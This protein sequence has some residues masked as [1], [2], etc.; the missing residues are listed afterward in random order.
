MAAIR[1]WEGF[2]G[3]IWD[4]EWWRSVRTRREPLIDGDS[5]SE[6]PLVRSKRMWSECAVCQRRVVGTPEDPVDGEWGTLP[7]LHL[8]FSLSDTY[9]TC[10]PECAARIDIPFQ[11][12]P[13][14]VYKPGDSLFVSTET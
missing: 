13:V 10:G 11:G 14:P 7:S 2:V 9:I 1:A 6:I 5:F 12:R 3:E 8:T 4:R